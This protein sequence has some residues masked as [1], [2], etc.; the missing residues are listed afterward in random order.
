[1]WNEVITHF[2]KNG[3]NP[4]N[5]LILGVAAGSVIHAIRAHS[6]SAKIIGIEIDPMMKQIA[7]QH[8]AIHESKNQKIVIADAIPYLFKQ[9]QTYDLIIV[10][11]YIGPLNPQKSRT[12]KFIEQLKVVLKKNGVVFY[13]AHYQKKNTY[14]HENFLKKVTRVFPTTTEVFAYRLNRVLRLQR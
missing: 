3:G 14:E 1:M 12:K 13:N 10:D 2:Y 8:F 4:K 11:L 6:K 7:T 9:T 5:I